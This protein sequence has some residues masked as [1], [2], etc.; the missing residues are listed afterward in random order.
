M[1]EYTKLLAIPHTVKSFPKQDVLQTCMLC[2]L[3]IL[4]PLPGVATSPVSTWSSSVVLTGVGPIPPP[5]GSP[6]WFPQVR[7]SC[8][9]SVLTAFLVLYC[10]LYW[11]ACL[12]F[13]EG[14]CL[15]HSL[16]STAQHHGWRTGVPSK[17]LL[18]VKGT[19]SLMLSKK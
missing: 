16:I 9:L 6:P 1:S 2:L 7:V 18:N 3:H 11:F 13:H 12:Y 8:S 17:H 4:V 14:P 5:P 19:L 10:R 15:I